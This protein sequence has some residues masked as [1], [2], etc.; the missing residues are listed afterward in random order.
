MSV[1][2]VID[3]RVG[4]GRSDGYPCGVLSRCVRL[5]NLAGY[6]RREKDGRRTEGERRGS[7]AVRGGTHRKGDGSSGL[8][9]AGRSRAGWGWSAGR[10]GL[11]WR[12][13]R[14][15]RRP[16][17]VDVVCLAGGDRG[18]AGA[19]QRRKRKAPGHH[20]KAGDR[21]FRGLLEQAVHAA[22]Q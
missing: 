20:G 4:N 2:R 5:E 9:E 12:W 13:W 7:T 16:A 15:F 10:R 6:G 21:H 18:V 11:W 22:R 19:C 1:T 3:A 17:L 14:G 8:S